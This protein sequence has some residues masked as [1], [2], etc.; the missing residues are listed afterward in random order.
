MIQYDLM[1]ELFSPG[2]EGR[3]FLVPAMLPDTRDLAEDVESGAIL[4]MNG[5]VAK[6][7]KKTGVC[8]PPLVGSSTR[9][10]DDWPVADQKPACYLVFGQAPTEVSPSTTTT[11][12]LT[13][14]SIPNGFIPEG[15]WFTLLV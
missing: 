14:P 2:S 5:L 3:Q 6:L 15:F 10:L 13:S 12:H 11:N 4:R 8:L 1:F 7:Q 9:C